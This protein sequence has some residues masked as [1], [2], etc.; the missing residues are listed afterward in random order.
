MENSKIIFVVS[1]KFY[2]NTDSM[3]TLESLNQICNQVLIK[4]KYF[5]ENHHFHIPM[6]NSH[7]RK[8]GGK[9]G[10]DVYDVNVYETLHLVFNVNKM[11]GNVELDAQNISTMTKNVYHAALIC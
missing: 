5:H 6:G 9:I 3:C 7:C 4:Y 2:K 10:K 11:I 1:I 8:N